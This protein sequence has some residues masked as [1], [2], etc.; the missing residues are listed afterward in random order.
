MKERTAKILEAV[1][2]EFIKS[3]LPVSSLELYK[4]YDFNV[5]P[6]TI[7]AELNY[8][9]KHYF[10]SQSHHSAGR[11]PT[12]LAYRFFAEIS[13][14]KSAFDSFSRRC[15]DFFETEN[16]DDFI[17]TFSKGLRVLGI[18][19]DKDDD[20]ARKEG[21]PFLIKELDG[22]PVS[23]I[24]KIIEDFELIEER[25]RRFGGLFFEEDKPRIFIGQK[26]PFIRNENL[27]VI[28]DGY[29]LNRK[30]VVVLAVGPKRMN[31]Q[32]AIRVF[33]GLALKAKKSETIN[34]KSNKKN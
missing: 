23:E 6:A 21:L 18:S 3:G 11:Q 34:N 8:L 4:K 14:E 27:A 19:Y 24:S 1:V 2:R 31:Y 30:E 15:Q 9:T 25:I 17:K 13:E 32:R 20:L 28:G 26:N 22:W 33:N 12:D 7:R 5:K 16:M 29:Y 10:L